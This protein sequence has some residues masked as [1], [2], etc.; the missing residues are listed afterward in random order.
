MLVHYEL[1]DNGLVHIT[2]NTLSVLT[3][4]VTCN[5]LLEKNKK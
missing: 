3:C 2:A 1:T 4:F 5:I